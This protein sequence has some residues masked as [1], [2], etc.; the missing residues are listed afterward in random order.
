MAAFGAFSTYFVTFCSTL[1][2]PR[3]V[4]S[5]WEKVSPGSEEWTELIYYCSNIFSI[6]MVSSASNYL[7]RARSNG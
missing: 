2:V 6:F 7:T 1:E 3:G 4:K 5:E